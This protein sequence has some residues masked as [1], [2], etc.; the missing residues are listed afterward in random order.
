[1]KDFLLV[2][3]TLYRNRYAVQREVNTGKRKLSQST[4]ML[5]SLLPLVAL[6]CVML[7]FAAAQ[8]TSRYSLMTLFNAI[9][10]AV[11]L[12][13]LFMMLPTVLGTLY[14]SEDAPFLASLPVSPTSVFFAKL[15]LV[16]LAALKVAAIFLLPSMLTVSVTYAAI[17]NAMFYGFFPLLAL[18]V[19]VAPLLPLFIVV[20]FSM[21][22]MW[23]GSFLKG[24]SVVKTVFSLVFYIMLMAAY[25]V[26]VFFVNTKGFGQD[27]STLSESALE[28]LSL[29]SDV[30]YPNSALLSMCLGID[31]AK[32][33]GIS[34][35]IWLGLGGFTVLLA[36]L[37]Y[38]RITAKQA[39]THRETST[40][41]SSFRRS[42]PVVSL[43]RRDF[44]SVMRNP[45]MAMGTF[46]NII[47]APIVMT[48]MY[49]FMRGDVQ[50]N[51]TEFASQMMTE[52]IVLLYPIIFLG[53]TNMVAISAYSR[54][55]ESFFIA[56]ALP[57]APKTSVTAKL[58][59]ALLAAA[60]AQ[61]VIFV[62]SLALYRVNVGSAF[63]IT[64]ASLL[65][66]V[67]TSALHIYYDIKKGNVHWKSQSD[68]RG[69]SSGNAATL[70]PMTLCLIP[71]V[72]FVIMGVFLAGLADEI[73]RSGVLAVYWCVV[74]AA[75]GALAIAG[76]YILYEKGVPLYDRIGENRAVAKAGK[77]LSARIAK[78]GFLR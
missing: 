14:A 7:G 65:F 24:R 31:P 11:Q 66:C 15:L 42:R 16:Y 30:M 33:F 29:L 39:E 71:A 64:A 27:G 45:S 40:G 69:N 50:Q 8:L 60:A 1:M 34:V 73:G 37:F 43:V 26:F 61:L 22:V 56:K 46:S 47:L 18:I 78:D 35:G 51:V 5:I 54:E 57:I 72:L 9:L 76:L 23:I 2:F 59:F 17:G 63:G 74:L 20:V 32:N 62:L 4:V 28:A 12:F 77:K 38:R 52:G 36:G 49:F 75:A 6:L 13:V 41:G 3:K 55:G 68:M 21:P 10:S 48:V 58:L 19:V 25:M 70:I 44:L 53:G 67:G